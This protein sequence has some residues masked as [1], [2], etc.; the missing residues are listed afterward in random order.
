VPDPQALPHV[1]QAD[2]KVSDGNLNR[3]TIPTIRSLGCK[4]LGHKVY[5][6]CLNR[7]RPFPQIGQARSYDNE[8]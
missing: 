3:L 4:F 1:L 5:L 2:L 7:Y 6:L 8:C